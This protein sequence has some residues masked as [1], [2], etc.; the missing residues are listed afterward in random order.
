MAAAFA[1][2]V[3]ITIRKDGRTY[4]L[5]VPEDSQTDVDKNGNATVNIPAKA[6]NGKA[7]GTSAL[8]D[9]KALQGQWKVVHVKKQATP[10]HRG[11]QFG[12]GGLR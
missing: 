6:E 7:T 11:P 12:A 8:A 9:L 10:R 5:N 4:R 2:G 1:A 3:V